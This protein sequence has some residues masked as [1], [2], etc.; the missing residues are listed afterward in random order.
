MADRPATA[1]LALEMVARHH[2]ADFDARR[3]V[4]DYAV[5]T[6]S[7]GTSLLLRVAREHGFKAQ[8][9]KL[10]WTDLAALGDV[11]PLILRLSNGN[12]VVL[13]GFRPNDGL[14]DGG[15]AVIVDPLAERPAFVYL[16]REKLETLWRG[17]AVFVKRRYALN[18][19]NQPFSLRWFIPEILRQKGIF[20]HVALA[21]LLLHGIGLVTPLFFQVVIDKVLVHNSADTLMVLGVGVSIAVVFEA[22]IGFLRNYLLLH[23]TSKIDMRLS[24]RIFTHLMRLPLTFFETTAAGVT[25]KHM[26]QIERIREF[27]TGRLFSAVLDSWALLVFLPILIAYS[28]AMA[29]VVLTFSVLV[30]LAVL[31]VLPLFRRELNGLYSA[32]GRRQALLIEAIHGASTVK[33]LALE[34]TIG[35]RWADS[36]ALSVTM[37]MRVGRVS[38]A[39]QAVI[40]FLEKLMTIAI[41]WIGAVKVFDGSLSV[42]ELV[43]IQMLAGRVSG[44]LVQLVSLLNEFQQTALSVR[45]LGEIMNRPTEGGGKGGLRPPLRSGI[46]LEGVSF[47]YPG[48]PAPALNDISVT[49]PA[50]SM[51]GVVGRSGSGKTTF[52]RL[53]QGMHM[54]SGGHIRYDGIDI[55][56]IDLAHLRRQL[57]VV[58][59]ESFIFR[60]SVR[61]NIAMTMPGVT[62]AKVVEAAKLAGAD[63][64]IQ[65]LPHGYD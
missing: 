59:Q 56:E 33:A 29:G 4:H 17:E 63:E 48:A 32:E 30:A 39:A 45:M 13:S 21:G 57:G 27:L 20:G 22:V 46:V 3:A 6:G 65:R 44:P 61:E 19:E 31:V 8:A 64:F 25:A 51:I 36:S 35:R 34:P 60:G 24:T 2:G 58:L 41:V 49:I 14:A 40:G 18:E 28:P 12:S 26:Q 43:A 15:E 55:R 37:Q 5:E 7:I 38:Q 50:G 47:S 16:S 10:G 11:F 52:L 1:L 42:G 9:A 62:F 54:P 53:L 23:A